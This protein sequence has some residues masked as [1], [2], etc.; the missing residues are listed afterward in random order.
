M[1]DID[2]ENALY[3]IVEIIEDD[4]LKLLLFALLFSLRGAWLSG[5]QPTL[6]SQV[7]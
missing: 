2:F 7:K 3:A 5:Q 6:S 1:T 4:C